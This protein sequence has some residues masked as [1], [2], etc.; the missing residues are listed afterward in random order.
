[1]KIS[2]IIILTVLVAAVSIQATII[3]V[4]DDY[5]TIQAGI[6]ASNDDDTVLVE[7][8]T[9]AE[10][11]NYGGK[12]IFLTS[13]FIFTLDL[14]D[15][16]STLITGNDLCGSLITF[17]SNE[18]ENT[19]LYGFTITGGNS[20]FGGA[21]Y[22]ENSNPVI[23]NCEFIGNSSDGFGGAIYCENSY[24]KISNNR[25]HQNEAIDNGGTIY[26]LNSDPLIENNE[27]VSG[28]S[29]ENAGAIYCW[30]SNP[31]IIGNEFADNLTGDRGGAIYLWFSDPIIKENNFFRNQAQR[32]GGAMYIYASVP[33]IYSN[34]FQNNSSLERAGAIFAW[35]AD[36]IIKNNVI[37][38]NSSVLC[39][40]VYI[41]NLSNAEVINNTIVSNTAE[42]GGG[43]YS[44]G[45]DPLLVN[46]I[47]WYNQADI[48]PQ[49]EQGTDTNPIVRYCNIE[50]GY[51]GEGII[52]T[53]P[54]FRDS[55][56][57]DYHLMATYCDDPYDSPCIDAG[58]PE[59]ADDTLDCDWGLGSIRSDMGAYGGGNVQVGINDDKIESLLPLDTEILTNYPNPFNNTTVISFKLS[60]ADN[61]ELDIYDI[62]GR[63]IITLCNSFKEAGEHR[64]SWHADG[65]S[66]GI[67]FARLN[68]SDN[69]YT[70]SMLLIK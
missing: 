24:L 2:T 4:P 55:T 49:I 29:N 1:M 34:T 26:C 42:R 56:N 27:F 28:A 51:E 44:W 21:I 67:Y 54:L 53:E 25:F 18:N 41:G 69:S 8:G 46:N 57:L 32:Y 52:D 30:Y 59:I 45:C 14:I 19:F 6:D 7:R 37:A 36:P 47:F 23:M 5:S 62:L 33:L 60:H 70:V 40:G 64:L 22:C 12:E 13:L 58:D 61:V 66:S 20:M 17:N 68:I 31:V 50:G 35:Y 10:K 48:G 3:N 38:E 65:F 9:Y 43:F 39:G 15:I 16:D 11:I 63:K